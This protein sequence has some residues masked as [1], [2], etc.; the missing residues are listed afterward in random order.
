MLPLRVL[1][2][3][4]GAVLV[5]NAEGIVEHVF[6]SPSELFGDDE[7]TG[8]PLYE[9]I[10]LPDDGTAGLVQLWLA[11]V[12][13]NEEA[14]WPIYA[15]QAPRVGI[16]RAR[17]RGARPL[18]LTAAP[19]S[20]HGIVTHA[21][22]FATDAPA[23]GEHVATP[24]GAPATSSPT[25]DCESFRSETAGLLSDCDAALARLER[26][27]ASHTTVNRLFR[28]LHTLRGTARAFR[29][30]AVESAA[31][32]AEELLEAVRRA[33][34]PPSPAQLAA[35]GGRLR[36][37]RQLIDR[38]SAAPSGTAAETAVAD[39]LETFALALERAQG[40]GA[41]A[42]TARFVLER[43]LR[44]WQLEPLGNTLAPE[45]VA[46]LVR[47]VRACELSD[48]LVGE[49][50]RLLAALH[51]ARVGERADAALVVLDLA[52]A[53]TSSLGL[54]TLASAAA[55]SLAAIRGGA[56]VVDAIDVVERRLRIARQLAST[57][58]R[59][60]RVD[61]LAIAQTDARRCL[62]EM[63]RAL[64]VWSAHPRGEQSRLAT[65]ELSRYARRLVACAER[66]GFEGLRSQAAQIQPVLDEARRHA[67]PPRS[68]LARV[69]QWMSDAEAHLA[70]YQAFAVERTAV[71]HEDGT[72]ATLLSSVARAR[73]DE[74]PAALDQLRRAATAAGIL[75]IGA[76][77]DQE[78]IEAA[79]RVRRLCIDA[80]R[81]VAE[82]DHT[83]TDRHA[84]LAQ[85]VERY[86]RARADERSE[87]TE[88]AWN[89]LR[90]ALRAITLEPLATVADPLGRVA[91]D[92]ARTAG[93]EVTL[94][95]ECGEVS[96]PPAVVR[97]LS[98]VLAHAIR[99]AVDHGIEPPAARL[100]AGKPSRGVIWL[101]AS[102]D[103]ERLRLEIVDDGAGVA[104][105]A[106]RAR[107]VERGLV[108]AAASAALDERQLL[109]LLFAPGFTTRSEVGALSGRGVGLDAVRAMAEELS[110][111]ARL[112]SQP[113]RGCRLIVELS[114]RAAT[115]AAVAP[116]R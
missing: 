3:W 81:F 34:E 32:E 91:A 55:R 46:Q 85:A 97:K 11:S 2:S 105:D 61:V 27:P 115:A 84:A 59:A 21:I 15:D 71:G 36:A 42:Q 112:E 39:E 67:R 86:E 45:E 24:H 99:N 114:R 94:A 12:V 90:R 31:F 33:A 8:R 79:A 102:E 95:V 23:E 104:L 62:V 7:L 92:A 52:D 25:V 57:V 41:A 60:A 20:A 50:D 63:Q 100:A 22:L 17:E 68:L 38:L 58:R 82:A 30:S 43:C 35:I 65:D 93:R 10:G 66:F 106:V 14:V 108:D 1:A 78:P 44:R 19:L 49:A 56:R 26:D 74:L 54:T 110:G 28:S 4:P 6:G 101:I 83:A 72:I 9:V 48:V 88:A 53:A 18:A 13:G 70:L 29:L 69:E 73:V 98:T 77:L 76:A 80:P 116:I 75:S 107:A 40:S 16:A 96:A 47:E 51:A 37:L 87:A 64:E 89:A 113:G 109:E 103:D 111:S 5:V